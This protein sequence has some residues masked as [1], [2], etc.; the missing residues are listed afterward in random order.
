MYEKTVPMF[1]YLTCRRADIAMCSVTF[2]SVAVWCVHLIGS[3]A[4]VLGDGEQEIQLYY[5]VTYTVLSAILPII[6]AFAGLSIAAKFYEL[7]RAAVVRFG[8][9]AA[10]GLCTGGAATIM[11]YLGDNSITNFI[12][13]SSSE[14][15]CGAAGIA[16]VACSVG[17][18]LLFYWDKRWMNKIWRRMLVSFILALGMCG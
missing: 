8:S 6:P 11:Q 10:C 14:N 1:Q 16:V 18:S 13:L 9:L 12:V 4:I 15:T 17:F 2:G 5:D 3:R 7:D